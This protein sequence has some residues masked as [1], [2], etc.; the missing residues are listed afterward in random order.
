LAPHDAGSSLLG[1]S[2]FHGAS[3]WSQRPVESRLRA[4]LPAPQIDTLKLGQFRQFPKND[5]PD[6]PSLGRDQIFLAGRKNCSLNL[7]AFMQM[8]ADKHGQ[9]RPFHVF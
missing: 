6:A 3:S 8:N 5:S 9:D 2:S 4:G 1:G 7:D